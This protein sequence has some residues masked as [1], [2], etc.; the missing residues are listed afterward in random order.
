MPV[1]TG[2]GGPLEHGEE[3]VLFSVQPGERP[4]VAGHGIVV[5]P[6]DSLPRSVLPVRAGGDG[7]AWVIAIA[8]LPPVGA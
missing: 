4:V 8:R 3:H 5:P 1:E 2:R 7:A 6:Q